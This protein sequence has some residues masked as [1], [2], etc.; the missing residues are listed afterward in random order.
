MSVQRRVGMQLGGVSYGSR[1][2][3]SDQIVEQKFKPCSGT[4]KPLARHVDLALLETGHTLRMTSGMNNTSISTN[5]SHKEYFDKPELRRINVMSKRQM[6]ARMCESSKT[7]YGSHINGD[8]QIITN[9]L[10]QS[11]DAT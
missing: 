7:I 3:H 5:K 11:T 6:P 10:Q 1:Q 2:I 9:H 8:E 4:V